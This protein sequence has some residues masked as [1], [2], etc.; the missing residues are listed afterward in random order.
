MRAFL[1]DLLVSEYGCTV[2]GDPD[3][4]D[5]AITADLRRRDLLVIDQCAYADSEWR[6]AV[7][8]TGA[9]VVVVA[10][11]N[12][13]SSREAATAQGADGWLPREQL[14]ELLGGEIVRA[15]TQPSRPTTEG[16]T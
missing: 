5:A 11:E 4:G 7:T 3:Q 2:A 13:P 16:V 12:D 15:L 14:G 10:A 1:V 6:D 9:R 8:R